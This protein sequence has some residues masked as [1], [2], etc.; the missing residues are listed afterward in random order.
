M[1]V[2]LVIGSTVIS[3]VNLLPEN[4]LAAPSP[5]A[6]YPFSEGSGTTT[7]DASGN[8][9][10]GTLTN[11]PVWTMGKIGGGLSF[12]G[13]N[14]YVNL[15][16][17][18][19]STGAV[20]AC[21]WVY[22]NLPSGFT[23][24]LD[25]TR[26]GLYVRGFN[27]A[28]YFTS[29]GGASAVSANNSVPNNTW[30]HICVT[31]TAGGTGNV[32]VN[33][34]LSGTPNQSTGNPLSTAF[35]TTIGAYGGVGQ[36]FN[37]KIDEVRIYNQVL[38][39]QEVTDVYNDTGAPPDTT[40]P[41]I[42]AVSASP[43][44]YNSA[45]INWTTDEPAD[46]QVAFGLTTGYGSLSTL[47]STLTASHS[48]V[49]NGLAPNTLYHYQVR[50]RDA[51]NNLGQSLDF[52]FTTPV[53]TNDAPLVSAG[54]D[55]SIASGSVA[56]LDGMVSDD[57]LPNP[58]ST[59]TTIWTKI[60]GPGTV[61][62]GNAGAVDTTV[63][64]SDEGIYTLRLTA[65]DSALSTSDDA[66]VT[67]NPPSSELPGLV[68]SYP[69]DVGTGTLA[70]DTSGND[71]NGTLV[72]GP[73]WIAGKIGAG[74]LSFDGVNDHV[75]L[76]DTIIGTQDLT[77]CA[78]LFQRS[79]A[80]V[81]FNDVL[82]NT[83][84]SIVVDTYD[85]NALT[86]LGTSNGMFTAVSSQFPSNVWNHFCFIR[87][88]NTGTF[89]VNGVLSGTINQNIGTATATAFPATIGQYSSIGGMNLYGNVDELKIYNRPLSFQEVLSVYNSNGT[90]PSDA[91]PPT[92]SVTSP[93]SGAQLSG[94]V[95]LTATAADNVG[96]SG[97]Q[98]LLD[99]ADLGVEDTNAPYTISWDTIPTSNGSHTLTARARDAAVNITVSSPVNVTV[100]NAGF[101]QNEIVVTGTNFA[102]NLEFLPDGR[103]LLAELGGV[104]R[105][106]QPGATQPD[107]TPF[108]LLSNIGTSLGEQGLMDVVLDPNFATN[109]Y[110]Y[111]FY[112]LGSPN[113]DRVSRFTASGN[114]TV[115]GSEFVVWQDIVD[116][117]VQH[118]GG[119]LNFGNDGKLYVTVGEHFVP[120]D[121]QLLTTYHG[122]ILRINSDGT[123]PT[124]NPFDDGAGPNLEAIWAYGLRNPFRAYYDI[125]TGRFYIADVGGN[126]PAVAKEE[127]NIGVAGANYGWPNCE[128]AC[129]NPAYTDALFWYPHN[130]R[131]A[132]ITGGFIYHGTQYPSE[133]QGNYFYADY[134]QNWIRRLVLDVNG[135][136]VSTQ[137]FEPIDGSLDGP[138]GDIVYLS[139]GPDGA[140]YYVDL[141]ISDGISKVRRIRY[142][143]T[144]QPP[145]AM[146]A[147]NPDSGPAP[148][149]VDFSSTGS[150]DP[151][152]Q[153]LTYLWT[154]G[155][156][157]SSTAANPSHVYTQAGQ[158]T[159]R[160][161]VSDSINTTLAEPVY[162]TVGSKPTATILTPQNNALFRAGDVISFSGQAT[163]LED[164]TLPEST[165]SWEV[166]F[167]HEG[168][169][170][171]GPTFMGVT[172]GSFTVPT[173]G[174]DFQG[175][176]RYEFKL[177]VTDSNSLTDTKSV[178]VYPDK[179]NLSFNTSPSGL[180]LKLD[181][182]SKTA[183][184]VLDTL[185]GFQHTM[186][187][188]DQN[189]G[190]TSYNFVAWSD[191]EARL[192]TITV[193]TSAQSYT[194]TYNVIQSPLPSGL[195]SSYTFS[196]GSGTV[197]E[198][199][200]G[201]GHLGTLTNGPA[202]TTGKSGGG[203]LFD[204]TNDYVNLGSNLISTGT[205]SACAWIYSNYPSGFNSV[206]DNTRF[207]LLAR[208]YDHRVYFTSNGGTTV[209]SV[210]NALLNNTWT[211]VCVTRTATGTANLYVNGALSG[212]ANQNSGTPTSTAFPT[213]IGAYGGIGQYFNGKIDEVHLYDRVLTVS[214]VQQD[215]SNANP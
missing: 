69:L 108:L 16:N 24:V 112:T 59:V 58:P 109:G 6:A 199:S 129:G 183:P 166:N 48:V 98:F 140:L 84:F 76:N 179:V 31:R 52:T 196:E 181:G 22:S 191:G 5:I 34:V 197:A 53:Q 194:A 128:G 211:H 121:S 44:T 186:E 10:T 72:N 192:H 102:T 203:L 132:S 41:M 17:S 94:F 161:A 50:S 20:S 168:H 23:S 64:F 137:N 142:V 12:D 144:N 67:V 70:V 146:A 164:G 100:F 158:Y 115:S 56:N 101:F 9:N 68:G 18:L 78:W 107:P 40:A 212:S 195:I 141:G 75:V 86:L 139:E 135:N 178:V 188:P 124:D 39:S 175:N 122:K 204:G 15:G 210:D 131:D 118:H 47:N 4:A 176:T 149:T 215:M 90:I 29:N 14:D 133:Y 105:V 60:S 96:V 36:Y 169:V 120:S 55:Q 28:V 147:A 7:V 172:S 130:N 170:H 110:Y 71:N 185:I 82:D 2:M 119:A 177:T 37:G 160:L 162:V 151:E 73:T 173:S 167:L 187:A 61:T 66:V 92:V 26:F 134:A 125:P 97:V 198:D 35:P 214:E 85:S 193:P 152:N 3:T 27:H 127:V 32:Y 171:P 180:T 63:T 114:A 46:S 154:F 33:G 87:T 1:L 80:P 113:R 79:G 184:F 116:A 45:T 163:D 42:S 207:G 81:R 51:S 62:F 138:Y 43:V 201:N 136:V 153:P 143:Q 156:T 54:N 145:V 208:G 205:I 99:G 13:N 206:V 57:G 104:I 95:T 38:T 103:M 106:V 49:L 126:D 25:N 150:S 65:D 213:T 182:I 123:I 202:W 91:T 165:F 111:V 19:V 200:S 190:L 30:T 74:A 174:H 148:L 155:D 89:Y 83:R 11:G 159:V 21:A 8:S 77:V 88:S 117:D 209:G 93:T 189:Q 157:A